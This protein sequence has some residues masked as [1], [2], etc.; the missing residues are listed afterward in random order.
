MKHLFLFLL[1]L[2]ASQ[3]LSAEPLDPLLSKAAVDSLRAQ[4]WQIPPGINRVNVLLRLSNALVT[5]REELWLSLDSASAYN[6]QA[7]VLSDSL[8]FPSGQIQSL[9]LLGRMLPF[10]GRAAEGSG[11]LEQGVANSVHQHNKPLEATGWFY[12][13][14][15]YCANAGDLPR[16]LACFQKARN[17]FLAEGDRARAAYL[18]KRIAD[19][20]LVQTKYRQAHAELLQVLAQYRS[21]GYRRLH[22]TFDLLVAVDEQIANYEEAIQFG[23]AA[24]QS[25][26]ATHDDIFLSH[27]Y[28][29]LAEIHQTLHQYETS[30]SYQYLAFA[31]MKREE[32]PSPAETYMRASCAI[33][34]ALIDLHRPKQAIAFLQRERAAN[35]P[36]N[37]LTRYMLAEGLAHG[38]LADKQYGLAK[39]FALR[40]V[41]SA[42]AIARTHKDFD[43]FYRQIQYRAC[44]VL[45]QVYIAT[46]QFAK[47]RIY[48]NQAFVTGG[49]IAPLT[50]NVTFYLLLFKV[51]SAQGNLTDALTHYQH[52]KVLNDSIFNSKSSLVIANLRMQYSTEKREHSLALLTKQNFVQRASL[53]QRELQRNALFGG[54][55]LLA[56]L[57]GLGYNRYRL[58]QRSNRLLEA[59]QVEINHQNM[60]LARALEEKEWMLKEIHHRVKNNL[61]LISSLL[62]SQSNYL[63]DKAALS[64][65]RQSQNRVHSM[66]LIHQ[67]LYQGTQLAS[68][69]MQAY[70]HEIVSYLIASFES[71]AFVQAQ[72]AVTDVALDVSLAVPVGLILN[73]AI[74]NSLKYAFP[75]QQPGILQIELTYVNQTYRL[76]IGDNG[77][78]LP[79]DFDPTRNGTLGMSLIR[80]LSKQIDGQLQITGSAGVHITLAFDA[81]EAVFHTA[82][83]SDPQVASAT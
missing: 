69:P 66:A 33:A 73:E 16:G 63:Q 2:G 38:Y 46:H 58:K 34:D 7:L 44:V 65:I 79:P 9:Y 10:L 41:T 54:A 35:P 30:L 61:Q 49:D 71:Q 68:V 59:Q 12:L 8:H 62:Y 74:T 19:V 45:S 70:V 25:A 48:L 60:T 3:A 20:H 23:L 47:A 52:Y 22:Y 5:R 40:G 78:G 17:L 77:V 32:K 27:F 28:S 26:K 21:I 29:R 43:I 42:T 24:V 13:G 50:E 80:G 1:L 11:L 72:I 31:Q 56:L 4:L 53:R 14:N 51:D 37:E 64:A 55:L 76:T 75:A 83:D 36:I 18:L 39:M 82:P 67:K 6:Q 15:A 81:I 57:L